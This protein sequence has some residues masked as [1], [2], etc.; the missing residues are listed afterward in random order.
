MGLAVLGTCSTAIF[1]GTLY[2]TVVTQALGL[3]MFSEVMARNRNTL[4]DN[5]NVLT[6]PVLEFLIYFLALYMMLP[7]MLLS[8]GILRDSGI[9]PQS[10][11]FVYLVLVRYHIELAIFAF[12]VL[13]VQ[14]ILSL[15][16]G[17]L[18]YQLHRTGLAVISAALISCFACSLNALIFYGR[19]WPIFSTLVV[20]IND[21]SAY[22]AG[23]TFGATPL[24]KLS[25]KKTAEGFVGGL[26][27]TLLFTLWFGN[28]L[29]G[30]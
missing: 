15:Q 13:F 25:P 24:T 28:F 14:F 10:H 22:V 26:F 17:A 18:R 7:S 2:W 20:A 27:L 16:R 21:I 6:G 8:P 29:F 5:L 19:C 12:S 1:L 30:L 11:P 4:K 9:L 3:A 23:M